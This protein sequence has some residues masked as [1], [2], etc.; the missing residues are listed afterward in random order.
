MSTPATPRPYVLRKELTVGEPFG[1]DHPARIGLRKLPGWRRVTLEQATPTIHTILRAHAAARLA[2]AKVSESAQVPAEEMRALA[3]T[4]AE[5]TVRIV[6]V[7]DEEGAPLDA[8]DALMLWSALDSA[9]V[10]QCFGLWFTSMIV[11][12]RGLTAAQ[13]AA[14]LRAQEVTNDGE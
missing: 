3:E 4:L 13:I 8:S 14:A 10:V 6:G 2:K 12:D 7:E 9:A 1:P 5:A 11:D